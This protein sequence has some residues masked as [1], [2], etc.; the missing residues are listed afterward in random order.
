VTDSRIQKLHRIHHH[1][2]S[3]EFTSKTSLLPSLL[4]WGI[5]TQTRVKEFLKTMPIA[6]PA[7]DLHLKK[8]RLLLPE[9]QEL[10]SM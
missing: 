6:I 1:H 8:L 7:Q 2:E 4:V 5:K 9:R 10:N 3:T